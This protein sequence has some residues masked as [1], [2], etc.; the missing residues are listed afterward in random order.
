MAVARFG[1]DT[2]YGRLSSVLLHVPGTEIDSHPDP[3]SIQHLGPIRHPALVREFDAIT[4][5]FRRLG[6]EFSRDLLFMT[7]RGAVLANMANSTRSS[8]PMYAGRALETHGIPILHT[9][10]GEGRFEGAD[11]VWLRGDLVL[12]GVGNRTNY[13]G[14]QQIKAVLN[15]QGVECL[16]VPSHQ[17]QTQH[18]LGTLQLVDRN[19]ALVRHE[20]VDQA[21]I[22]L[23]ETHGYRIV[24][25]PESMEART[26]QAMNI[27][28]VAPR[29]IL[30]TAGCKETRS[31]FEQAGLT[32]AAELE[33]TQ[34]MRGAGGLACATGILSRDIHSSTALTP[35][36]P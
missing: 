15:V 10:C 11:A 29:T 36:M 12:V 17:T 19:L 32:I 2:E 20:I 7:P 34:L 30:M 13:H 25:I 18:L 23:L 28:T 26:R 16:H 3:A 6:I 31:L 35:S 1:A 14:Y 5:A 21:L 33:L 27:V 24:R 9:V 22:G 8:E 4:A